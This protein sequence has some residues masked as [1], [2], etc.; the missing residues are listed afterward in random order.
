M[1]AWREH[2]GGAAAGVGVLD[3]PD[4]A[5]V[6]Q[7][8]AEIICFAAWSLQEVFGRLPLVG[9]DEEPVDLGL[10]VG[11]QVPF[12]PK[13]SPTA[14]RRAH[15]SRSSTRECGIT[16]SMAMTLRLTEEQTEALRA[17]AAKEGRS[18]EH[19]ARSAIDEYL[20]RANDDERTDHA[21]E[22]GA[23]RFAELL[24]RLGE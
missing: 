16:T 15:S 1:A 5:A 7:G 11:C 20:M 3:P 4:L 22:Q 21:A 8:S 14:A 23:Q 18:M 6:H 19:V 9:V 2:A 24:R 12:D 13:R 17:L 10:A